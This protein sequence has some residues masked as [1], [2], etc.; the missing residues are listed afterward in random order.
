[1]KTSIGGRDSVGQRGKALAERVRAFSDGLD[2]VRRSLPRGPLEMEDIVGDP[3]KV[4]AIIEQL[5]V[6]GEQLSI[7][8]EE[9]RMQ[10]EELV[11][12]GEALASEQVRYRELFELGPEP[13]FV[14]DAAGSLFEANARALKMFGR[15]AEEL[16]K[17]PL[18]AFVDGTHV[19]ELRT[20]LLAL[21]PAASISLDLPLRAPD[22]PSR[23][24][25]LHAA[26]SADGER[27][28]WTARAVNEH[29][30]ELAAA[31]RDKDDAL[32]RERLLLE[33]LAKLESSPRD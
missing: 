8:E 31:L 20:A 12:L 33:R 15:S 4:S 19:G 10:V 13:C 25:E 11:D 30:R 27:I 17:K 2:A 29:P 32:E 22:E 14:T 16:R 21:A 5:A 3:L 7:A 24:M 6:E 28:L 23:W 18:A 9:L 1:V 26:R